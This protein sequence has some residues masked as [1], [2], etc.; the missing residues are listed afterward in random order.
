MENAIMIKLIAFDLDDTLAKLGKGITRDNLLKLKALEQRGIQIAVCSGK[1]TYYLCG[2]MRQAGLKNPALVG[3]NGAVIQ[4][5]VNL[6]PREFYVQA[7]S[8]AAQQSIRLL[9]AKITEA[10]PHMW[11]QPNMVCLTPFPTSEEE[12]KT[13]QSII[14]A[15]ANEL[16]D[17]DVYHHMDSFDIIPKGI[18]KRSGLEF[19]GSLLHITPAETIAVGNGTNDYPMFD[20][21]GF[22]AGIRVP[23]AHKVDVNFKTP[24][25]ALDFLLQYTNSLD[26]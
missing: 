13:I 7:H 25:E 17:I 4:I 20:C 26:H 5:G 14:D 12:H 21:A 22:A 2:F 6:P 16:N 24:S 19:L 1:P 18:N 3:E 9:Q 15:S 10:I 8:S 23:D 11:Y